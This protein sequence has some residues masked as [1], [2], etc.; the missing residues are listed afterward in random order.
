KPPKFTDYIKACIE[1]TKHLSIPQQMVVDF[2]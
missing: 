2:K 1:T